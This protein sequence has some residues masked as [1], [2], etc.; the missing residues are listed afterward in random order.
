[1]S[2]LE[3]CLLLAAVPLV[4]LTA[5]S[6]GKD[7]KVRMTEYSVRSNG[8]QE[9]LKHWQGI[10]KRDGRWKLLRQAVRG[11]IEGCY[12]LLPWVKYSHEKVLPLGHF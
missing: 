7:A 9:R 10:K 8:V 4:E 2:A 5:D 12:A 3:H 11:R 6:Y 1:L